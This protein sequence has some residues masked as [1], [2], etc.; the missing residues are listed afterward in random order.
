MMKFFNSAAGTQAQ[1]FLLSDLT[2]IAVN[3]ASSAKTLTNCLGLTANPVTN[4]LTE[5]ARWEQG[6]VVNFE[7][8]DHIWQA[9][10][11]MLAAKRILVADQD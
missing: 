7:A 8:E 6:S 5:S 3:D 9:L 10:I 11:A 2:A 1:A 4:S